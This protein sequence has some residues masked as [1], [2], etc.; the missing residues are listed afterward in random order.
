[1]PRSL[2]DAFQSANAMNRLEGYEAT[3]TD[4]ELQER[5]I[6]GELTFDEAVQ[7]IVGVKPPGA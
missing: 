2:R 4:I 1:M 3:D 7:E 6:S 5:V